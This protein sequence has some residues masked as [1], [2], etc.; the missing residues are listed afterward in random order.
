MSRIG[1]VVLVL[2][3][4]VLGWYVLRPQTK[5]Q[6]DFIR[7]FPTAAETPPA[8]YVIRAHGLEQV[9]EGKR[10]T[11]NGLS[12]A[13][14]EEKVGGLWNQIQTL[15]VEADRVV[16]HVPPADYAAYGIDPEVRSVQGDGIALA[17]GSKEGKGYAIDLLSGR[18]AVIGPANAARFDALTTRLDSDLLFPPAA[19]ESVSA[20][21]ATFIKR[22][23]QW[24]HAVDAARPEAS[25]RVRDLGGVLG[26]LRLRSLE[27]ALPAEPGPATPIDLVYGDEMVKAGYAARY[28]L[29]VFLVGEE[30]WWQAEGWPAQRID[31]V[32]A[33]RLVTAA[34]SF[35]Q[36]RLFNLGGGLYGHSMEDIVFLKAGEPW[37]RLE[38][39]H[40]KALDDLSSKWDVVWEGG[41]EYADPQAA[42]R[43]A[44]ALN[45]IVV[46]NVRP[47][48]A[49]EEPWPDALAL[50][51]V[52]KGLHHPVLLEWR[53]R[54]VRSAT[55]VGWAVDLPDL[56][57]S[58]A[59]DRFLDAVI[60]S[61]APERVIK[62]QRRLRDREPPLEETFVCDS[63]GVWSRTYPGPGPIDQVAVQRM[64]RALA[65]GV[66]QSVRF[67]TAA[68]R[69]AAAE[70]DLEVAVRFAP[71][72]E[73]KANDFTDLDETTSID[74]GLAI[75][76]AG[77]PHSALNL[78][79]GIVY[80]LD[81]DFIDIFR[82]D[83]ASSLVMPLIPALVSRIII[84]GPPAEGGGSLILAQGRGGWRL[85]GDGR[86]DPAAEVEVRRLLRDLAGLT[87]LRRI[88]GGPLVATETALTVSVELPGAERDL[89]ER[90]LLQVARPGTLGAGADECVVFAESTR[91]GALVASR[92]V[93]PAS[94]A[95]GF[96]P[97]VQRF[98]A[99]N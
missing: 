56:I 88:E 75:G 38:T 15:S 44:D 28:H 92:A 93:I 34:G 2:L 57:A 50:S 23:A 74:V 47:R 94:I 8:R 59:P 40:A 55:H 90:M 54:Q 42:D 76:L 29:E 26:Q 64:A 53:G 52:G 27:G 48:L 80:T 68:D 79:S 1:Y 77:A 84:S 22:G 12:L 58:C 66:A 65:A 30:G 70:A 7:V 18:L 25:A 67:A 19:P 14:G 78:G 39:S 91:L 20:A 4:L 9:V 33:R 63:R 99:G 86:S 87:A 51:A 49:V 37:F 16:E 10:V 73:G 46:N 83:V 62:V 61:R 24:V 69:A 81:P 17:W 11:I 3:I 21:G 97:D 98:A 85:A 71:K 43:L 60:A 45:A 32:L 35:G 72:D 13:L 95:T 89:V 96:A 5:D 82:G 31:V 36:D 6:P 41:R